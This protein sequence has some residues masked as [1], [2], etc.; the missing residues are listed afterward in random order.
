MRKRSGLQRGLKNNREKYKNR[1][2]ELALTGYQPSISDLEF[3]KDV[4]SNGGLKDPES[5]SGR[6]PVYK[7]DPVMA[8][9]CKKDKPQWI[10]VSWDYYP[11]D[12]LEQQQ[13]DAI[14]HH[15]NFDYVYNF[16]FNPEKV[17]GQPY[18]PQSKP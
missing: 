14:I 1:L 4:F 7:V 17:K 12:A 10:L 16:F 9:L 13:Q 15:F 8:E 5:T 6:M 18:K 11:G 3:E 2:D